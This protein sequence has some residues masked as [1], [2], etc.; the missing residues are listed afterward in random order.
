MNV[1]VYDKFSWHLDANIEEKKLI[2]FYTKLMDFLNKHNFLNAYGLEL[3]NLGIDAS[4]SI[5]S[6]MLTDQGN[7]LLSQ[8]YDEFL[9]HANFDTEIDFSLLER[10]V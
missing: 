3:Y 6:K 9:S 5:N 10:N 4:L 2:I 8:W 1:K 7:K